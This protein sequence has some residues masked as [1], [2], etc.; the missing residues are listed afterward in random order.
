MDKMLFQEIF[1]LHNALLKTSASVKVIPTLRRFTLHNALLK[2]FSF[3]DF[4]QLIY[5]F[6]LHNALL[7]TLDIKKW[8]LCP[9]WNL[10]YT[11]LY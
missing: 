11:M 1:T 8:M 10:H 4:R 2:T 3:P 9:T 5:S 7:K 6:T